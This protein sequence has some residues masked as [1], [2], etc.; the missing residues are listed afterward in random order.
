MN[1]TPEKEAEKTFEEH[2]SDWEGSKGGHPDRSRSFMRAC[3]T[4]ETLGQWIWVLKK[5]SLFRPFRNAEL[6]KLIKGKNGTS[7]ERQE[8]Y[9]L[10]PRGVPEKKEASKFIQEKYG[11]TL[12]G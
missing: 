8:A 4:A 11:E 10:I 9:D 12:V 6:L 5:K 1:N 7:G 2:K 3:N